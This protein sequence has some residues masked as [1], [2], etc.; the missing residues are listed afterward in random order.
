VNENFSFL[1]HHSLNFR[2]AYPVSYFI[3]ALTYL[4]GISCQKIE[5]SISPPVK[6]LLPPLN[7]LNLNKSAKVMPPPGWS[8]GVD[9][10]GRG[11]D[12]STLLLATHMA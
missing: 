3:S 7:E 12:P 10:R 6:L 2:Q 1:V 8:N 11:A 4:T 5:P 9:P